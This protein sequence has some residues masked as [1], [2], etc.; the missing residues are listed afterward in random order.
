MST[1][2]SIRCTDVVSDYIDVF[3][4]TLSGRFNNCMGVDSN[5]LSFVRSKRAQGFSEMGVTC[6]HGASL[7]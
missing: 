1:H 7:G 2:V 6:L 5:V 3:D 4:D